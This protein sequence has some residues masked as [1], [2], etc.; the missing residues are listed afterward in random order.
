MSRYIFEAIFHCIGG[1]PVISGYQTD[2]EQDETGRARSE[3]VPRTE[4]RFESKPKKSEN[5]PIAAAYQTHLI[6]RSNISSRRGERKNIHCYS[7][8]CLI[9]QKTTDQPFQLGP[10]PIFCRILKFIICKKTLI[11][12]FLSACNIN[13]SHWVMISLNGRNHV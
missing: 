5:R 10:R 12:S 8:K 11:W 9:Y 4:L 3:T 7:K 1:I 6:L 13:L 2:P